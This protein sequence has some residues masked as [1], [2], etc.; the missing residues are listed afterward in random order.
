MKLEQSIKT[1]FDKT[2]D[3]EGRASRSEYW[4]WIF[5]STILEIISY[6]ISPYL[7]LAVSLVLFMPSLAVHV[8][9]L[10]D[11]NKSGNWYFIVFIPVIGPLILL[12][13]MMCKG[14][15]GKNRFDSDPVNEQSV[16][17]ISIVVPVI[18]III[19]LLASVTFLR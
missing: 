14:S 11:I 2:L 5:F 18:L 6:F 16:L 10:H 13:W 8:R 7:T 12:F 3:Y 9:R 17:F 4:Y 15:A 19:L 1:C